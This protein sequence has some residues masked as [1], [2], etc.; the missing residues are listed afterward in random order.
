[1]RFRFGHRRK[2]ADEKRSQRLAERLRDADVVLDQPIRHAVDVY[3]TNTPFF[4]P[5]RRLWD[6][7]L[8]V[9]TDS[10][11]L[12]VYARPTSM[13]P[14]GVL[15]LHRSTTV[16]PVGGR[17]ARLF[18]ERDLW[19]DRSQFAEVEAM[20]CNDVR[21]AWTSRAGFLDRLTGLRAVVLLFGAV[22]FAVLGAHDTFTAANRT[23]QL[24]GAWFLVLAV[25]LAAAGVLLRSVRHPRW[26]EPVARAS[27]AASAVTGLAVYLAFAVSRPVAERR[28]AVGVALLL[29]MIAVLAA[30]GLV[31]SSPRHLSP[32]SPLAWTKKVEWVGLALAAAGLLW[33]VFEFVWAN[34][35]DQ[36]GQRAIVAMNPTVRDAGPLSADLTRRA[37]DIDVTMAHVGNGRVHV[38]DAVYIVEL[39]QGTGHVRDWDPNMGTTYAGSAYTSTRTGE[40]FEVGSI[41]NGSW[42]FD[43]SEKVSTSFVVSVPAARLENVEVVRVSV[44]LIAAKGDRLTRATLLERAE[45][46]EGGAGTLWLIRRW[47]AASVSWLR[48]LL[49]GDHVIISAV[50]LR[51]PEASATAVVAP[52]VSACLT[53]KE[54]RETCS[55]VSR[56]AASFY[57]ITRTG[58]AFELPLVVQP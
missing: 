40:V 22:P 41:L 56:R 24:I 29:G 21:V 58:S 54:L 48:S 53:F 17:F 7:H 14:R 11:L 4:W 1:M 2:S 47:Q 36:G 18:P 9:A 43:K 20:A 23:Y 46:K 35:A 32:R 28:D 3:R 39:L 13:S 49:V 52:R 19:V 12:V 51:A 44:E 30:L 50:Q 45:A 57:G 55:N 25:L 26:R 42:T 34:F 15:W 10:D 27:G 37:F 16:G 8:V 38:L 5:S 6:T 33:T 31:R